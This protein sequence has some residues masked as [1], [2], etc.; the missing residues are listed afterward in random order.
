MAKVKRMEDEIEGQ[1]RAVE[2]KIRS[3]VRSIERYY[4]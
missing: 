4:Y 1:M 3:E 2:A